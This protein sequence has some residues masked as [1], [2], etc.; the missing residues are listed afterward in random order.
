MIR[1][2]SRWWIVESVGKFKS[3]NSSPV[4]G[5]ERSTTTKG[6]LQRDRCRGT[7]QG[8]GVERKESRRAKLVC[9]PSLRRGCPS[10]KSFDRSSCGAC[11]KLE[12]GATALARMSDGVRAR[13]VGA[14]GKGGGWARRGQSRI[15]FEKHEPPFEK[16][17]AEACSRG[18][19]RGRCCRW[20]GERKWPRRWCCRSR[21][22]R[23]GW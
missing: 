6:F 18:A 22:G 17:R 2:R 3:F 1:W 14:G 5:A 15:G 4:G 13:V 19:C 16:D 20:C 21:S 10:G 8:G 12:D 11:E 7:C 23:A 9:A